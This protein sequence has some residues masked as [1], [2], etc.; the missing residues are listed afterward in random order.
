MKQVYI[1]TSDKSKIGFKKYET[2]THLYIGYEITPSSL[3]MLNKS[4]L[5]SHVGIY[6]LLNEDSDIYIGES[7]TIL[8]RLKQHH[9]EEKINWTQAFVVTGQTLNKTELKQV[10]QEL[11]EESINSHF[12]VTNSNTNYNREVTKEYNILMLKAKTNLIKSIFID[13]GLNLQSI[14]EVIKSSDSKEFTFFVKGSTGGKGEIKYIEGTFILTKGSRLADY[15]QEGSL[16]SSWVSKYNNIYKKTDNGVLKEDIK[17]NRPSF[18]SN[19]ILG[20][21]SNGW[22]EWKNINGKTLDE[23]LRK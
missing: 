7:E 20:R 17:N 12:N 1:M 13:L 6:I 8:K 23:I 10:E 14:D 2:E 15:V 11:I 5:E 4:D 9:K 19:L 21:N 18:L 16:K 3:A 22:T